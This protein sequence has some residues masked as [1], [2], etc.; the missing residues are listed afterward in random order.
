M[1]IIENIENRSV[2]SFENQSEIQKFC[3]AKIKKN[4]LPNKKNEIWRLTSKKKLTD[5]LGYQFSNE[6]YKPKLPKNFINK[7]V[8]RIIIGEKNKIEYKK[9]NWAVHQMKE[10]EIIN[11]IK[12]KVIKSDDNE[13]WSDLLNHSLSDQNN[14]IGLNISGKEIPPIE[15]FSNSKNNLFNAKTLILNIEDNTE[16]NI[17]QVNLGDQNSSLSISSYIFIGEESL[18]N[19]G[20]ISQGEKNSNLINSLNVIQKKNSEYNL[21]SLQFKFNFARLEM[22]LNQLQGNAK[23]KIKGMQITQNNEQIS[24]YAKILFNGPNGFLDQLNKS[25][26]KDTSH[27]IFEGLIIVPQIAQ[28]TDASQLSRNILLSNYAKIDTKPQL[29]IIADDVKC[30]HGATISQLNENELFYMRSRGLT[31]EEASKLQLKSYYQEIISFIPISKDKWD[32]LDLLL[33]KQ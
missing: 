16:V 3:L 26:A 8:I 27:S 29:E 23:T 2:N 21:G 22:N 1:Q 12:N 33:K 6:F 4:P 24:T 9:N 32:L 31:L 19:H 7:N 28:K 11:L 15:I 17:V 10:Q 20:I 5:F 18:V 30:K 14:I 25:L 13:N